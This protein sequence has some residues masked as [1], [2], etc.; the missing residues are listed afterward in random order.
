RSTQLS[1]LSRP[2]SR[3]SVRVFP[4]PDG[5]RMARRRARVVQAT[6]SSKEPR[7]R[8]NWKV[9][10]RSETSLDLCAEAF[11]GLPASS[12]AE[13]GG[14]TVIFAGRGAGRTLMLLR[15]RTAIA[16]ANA[17]SSIGIIAGNPWLP[18][19]TYV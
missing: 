5:P 11:G 13:D 2:A 14:A 9:R 10:P 18:N 3:R 12:I 7:R 1:A 6:S 16:A 19:A 15:A 8:R 17:G 4:D